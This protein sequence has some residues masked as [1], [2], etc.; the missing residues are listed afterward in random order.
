MN[1][2]YSDSMPQKIRIKNNRIRIF[3]DTQEEVIEGKKRYKYLYSDVSINPSRSELI[4][5]II[6]DKYSKD[7]E[8]A[9]INNEIASPGTSEYL[10]YQNY[11]NHAKEIA[12]SILS[13]MVGLAN[14]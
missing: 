12:D 11:R 6:S 1:T 14:D 7:A 9:L 4:D 10:E 2:G 3:Y 8:I 13:Y 5:T